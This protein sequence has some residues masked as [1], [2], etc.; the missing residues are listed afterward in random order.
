MFSLLRYLFIC[1]IKE[2]IVGSADWFKSYW[3]FTQIDV[4]IFIFR[5]HYR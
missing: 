4:V 3:I 1:I 5:G 2:D